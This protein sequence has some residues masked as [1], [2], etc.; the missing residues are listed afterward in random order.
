MPQVLNTA[1]RLAAQH[2]QSIL[3]AD[4]RIKEEDANA[5]L[6]AGGCSFKYDAAAQ[7]RFI[8]WLEKEHLSFER[9]FPPLGKGIIIVPYMGHL[10]I[11]V[12]EKLQP[13]AYRRIVDYWET[14]DGTPKFENTRLYLVPA[15]MHA[16]SSEDDDSDWW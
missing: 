8:K 2:G 10:A 3:L 1:D 11:I 4:F 9:V 15:D 12:D 7:A 5:I 13:E 16:E 14:P 6:E